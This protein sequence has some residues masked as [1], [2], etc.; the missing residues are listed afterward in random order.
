VRHEFCVLSAEPSPRIVELLAM[1]AYYHQTTGLGLGHTLP[2]GEPW[3]PGSACDCFLLSTP[4]PFG[5]E[6][7]LC[8]LGDLRLRVLWA[9]PI[10]MAERAFKVAHGLEA[11]EE[12]FDAAALE[13]W[14]VERASVVASNPRPA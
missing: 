10:T 2:I 1:L 12:R 6:L 5:P 4:Y 7:E 11:L 14:N 9:L 13:Y 8:G 3:L